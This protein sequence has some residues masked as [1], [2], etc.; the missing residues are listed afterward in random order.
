MP[1]SRI[2]S[3]SNGRFAIV[4]PG[5]SG[6]VDRGEFH[7]A[8]SALTAGAGLAIP[9]WLPSMT[10][11][12]AGT[13]TSTPGAIV[14]SVSAPTDRKCSDANV[15]AG[16]STAAIGTPL[17]WPAVTS[18]RHR[19][20]AEP[21]CDQRVD[22]S[23]TRRSGRRS[24][25]TSDRRIVPVRP[26]M[27]AY[28][29]IGVVTAGRRGRGRRGTRTSGRSAGSGVCRAT[30]RQTSSARRRACPSE[31]KGGSRAATTASKREKSM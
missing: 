10:N 13:V 3:P 26:A 31:P 4:L 18:S 20:R 11:A 21:F 7:T 28:R 19:L 15:S 16:L 17:D 12:P 24:C 29:A 27:P 8:S 2:R 30:T 14:A 1:R 22:L 6:V 5:T 25:R 9:T 23:R